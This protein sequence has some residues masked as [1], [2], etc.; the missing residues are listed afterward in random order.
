MSSDYFT[1]QEYREYAGDK[2]GGRFSEDQIR[3]AQAEVVTSLEAWARTAW[4]NVTAR[5]TGSMTLSD[6][7]L[8][9]GT[10][11]FTDADVGQAVR[12]VGAGTDGADLETTVLSFTDGTHVELT[13]VAATAVSGAA[14]YLDGDGTAAN[15]R[16]TT[17]E[18]EG[19]TGLLFTS[20]IPIIAITAFS[21]TPHNGTTEDLDAD[22]YGVYEAGGVIRLDNLVKR[23]SGFYSLTYTYGSASCPRVV[24]RPTLAATRSL[25][26]EDLAPSKVP[27][28]TAQMTTEATTFVFG[29]PGTA[30]SAP[31]PWDATASEAMRSYWGRFRPRRAGAA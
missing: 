26:R 6:A 20:D 29:T 3:E 17:Q 19:G 10:G 24:K 15:L 28:N 22:D 25:L 1:V 5:G 27:S 21:F 7:T 18:F 8:T 11:A 30:F 16:S 23:A 12:V 9:L 31:W 4:P 13:A 2:A 14:V